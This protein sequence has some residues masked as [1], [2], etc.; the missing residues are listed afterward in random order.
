MAEDWA[1][2]K[3]KQ[4]LGKGYIPPAP[5][6]GNTRLVPPPPPIQLTPQLIAQYT[7][8]A[9]LPQGAPAPGDDQ[10]QAG[11]SAG[12][13]QSLSDAMAQ[14][15]AQPQVAI[16]QAQA[17]PDVTDLLKT[18]GDRQQLVT[19]AQKRLADAK[20][21]LTP[22]QAAVPSQFDQQL[23]DAVQ[24]RLTKA[25]IGGDSRW[26]RFQKGYDLGGKFAA[27]VVA[28]LV[29]VLSKKP[30]SAQG[31]M[32]ATNELQRQAELADQQRAAERQAHNQ[33][34]LNLASLYENI[35][36]TSL[37]N[38]KALLDQHIAVH[39]AN[40]E[41]LNNATKDVESATNSYGDALAK[42]KELQS[43]FGMDAWN[44]AAKQAELGLQGGHLAVAQKTLTDKEAETGINND[45]NQK[46]LALETKNSDAAKARADAAAQSADD[47]KGF[48]STELKLKALQELDKHA[49]SFAASYA[50]NANGTPKDPRHML[51]DYFSTNPAANEEIKTQLELA[52]LKTTPEDY[53]ASLTQQMHP[54]AIP[55]QDDGFLGLGGA[56]NALKG[57]RQGISNLGKGGQSALPTKD[58]APT[59]SSTPDIRTQAMEEAKRR[60]LLKNNG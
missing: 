45:L 59:K 14:P 50:T 12:P 34:L 6:M 39:K 28:P 1:D 21:N 13:A 33:T 49:K 38:S 26:D 19:D 16:P 5:A 25:L 46:K 4:G 54:S 35:S 29:G 53:L 15:S 22:E 18:L 47:N 57:I 41:D 23:S 2:N 3:K 36:P 58:T 43:K 20:G 9:Q 24:Q 31:A 37:K 42:S 52:G 56:L 48:K 27:D 10:P 32:L 8:Q 30:G 11:L 40:Q 44:Q 7:G 17:M 60:G 51:A 55:T